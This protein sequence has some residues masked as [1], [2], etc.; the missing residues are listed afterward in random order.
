MKHSAGEWLERTL[1]QFSGKGNISKMIDKQSIGKRVANKSGIGKR[2]EAK[3]IEEKKR[4]A[5]KR[6]ASKLASKPV[7]GKR[8]TGKPVTGNRVTTPGRRIALAGMMLLLLSGAG[9]DDETLRGGT[10]KEGE[11]PS[12]VETARESAIPYTAETLAEGLNVPWEMAIAP[13]GRI[14]FTE[15]PGAIRV[16]E[17][18]RLAKEP[19]IEMEAPF[20][21]RSEG[22]LLGLAIDPNFEDNRFLYAY[23]TYETEEGIRNRVIR[24]KENGN[25][26]E[27]DQVLIDGLPGAANHNGGRIKIGPDGYLYITT[28]DRYEPGL[29]QERE[30]LGGKILRIAPDGSIPQDNPFPGSPV[31]S[32]GHRNPQGLAWHPVTGQ[33]YASEHGQS[34]HD[35]VNRIEAGANYGWPIV[36]GDEQSGQYPDL[37]KP[38]LHSGEETWAPSGMAFIT[39]GPW[40]NRLLVANLAGKQALLIELSEPHYNE[41]KNVEALFRDLGRIRNIY[42]GPDGSVYVMTNNRDGRG[43]PQQGDDKMIRLRPRT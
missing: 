42:E 30:S 31:Y 20:I 5:G 17:Q 34:A 40:K 16:I 7:A 32:L 21:S 18:D 38:L 29:A 4:I 37:I 10:A 9:C 26:A 41:A 12:A 19:L 13:D 11:G 36:Q 24:L 43:N 27:I 23:H 39:Q 33:L 6:G 25:K 22:G 2:I 35:E 8:S 28:G 15:R 1:G 14:F 3:R